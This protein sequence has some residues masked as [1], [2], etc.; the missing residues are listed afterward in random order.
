M[1]ETSIDR[2]NRIYAPKIHRL[3][4]DIAERARNAGLEASGE[5]DDWTDEDYAYAVHI[6]PLGSKDVRKSGMV[7]MTIAQ[8]ENWDG[9][10]GGVNFMLDVDGPEDKLGGII[11]YNYSDKVWVR[12]SKPAAVEQRFREILNAIDEDEVVE[13]IKEALPAGRPT[14]PPEQGRLFGDRRRR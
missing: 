12:R 5:I 2:I 13:T 11:P 9:T 10:P 4:K 8:S 7:K 6:L 3:L 14:A 1:A